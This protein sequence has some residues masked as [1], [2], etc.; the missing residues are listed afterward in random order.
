MKVAWQG[1]MQATSRAQRLMCNARGEREADL[2]EGAALAAAQ[3]VPD[4]AHALLHARER[5]H[6]GLAIQQPHACKGH[7][8]SSDL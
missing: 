7:H 5:L 3:A 6:Q 8:L 4:A 1:S 2:V